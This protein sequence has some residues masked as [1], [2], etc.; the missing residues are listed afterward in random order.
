MLCIAGF[1]G[2]FKKLNQAWT[3]TLGYSEEELLARPYLDFVHPDDRAATATEAGKSSQGVSVVWFHNRYGCRDGS[4]R[5]LLWRAAPDTERGLIYAVARDVTEQKQLEDQLKVAS[6][7][8]RA[9]LDG[10]NFTIISTRPDGIIQTM[11]AGALRELGYAAEEL[12]GKVTPAII[13]DPG[14][15]V[16]RARHLS[17]ELG[18]P[19]EP[20]FETFIAKARLGQPD[21]NE[22]T[23]IRKDGSRFPIVLSVT[24][25]L[26]ASGDIVGFL[27]IGSNLTD[28]KRAEAARRSAEK[29][30]Q[31]IMDNTSAVIFVKG[32]DG[33][34]LLVNRQYEGLFHVTREEMAGKRDEDIFP[35]ELAHVL[36]E[37]DQKAI[38][39]G[40]P[41]QFEEIV[42]HDDG[43]HTY[44]SVKFP[45]F[46]AAGAVS[47]LCGI[48]MDITD[49]KRSEERVRERESRLRAILDNAVEG[50][51]TV[52]EDGLIQ[53]F[54]TAAVQMFGYEPEEVMGKNVMVLMGETYH[55]AHDSGVRR[56]LET[57]ERQ[58]IGR[59]TEVHG[60]HKDG[61]VFP[62]ELAV[63]ET[64]VAGGRLFTGM[65]H[66][67]AVRKQAEEDLL[68]SNES[69]EQFAYVASHDLKEPLRMVTSYLQ[70]L[71]RRYAG[72][73]D[74][75]AREFIGFAVDGATRMRLLIDDLLDYSRVGT[76][77]KPLAATDSAAVLRRV[78]EDLK[79]AIEEAGASVTHDETLPRVLADESQVA[80]VFQNLIANSLKFRGADAPLVHVGA[81][82][83][84]GR[85][86]FSVKDN[87]IG[88]HEKFFERIFV[89]FQ[90]LHGHEQYEGTGIGLAVCKKIIERH[91]GRLWVE[92]QPGHGATFFFTLAAADE[93][94]D[95]DRRGPAKRRRKKTAGQPHGEK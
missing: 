58:V 65:V 5:W 79:L 18:T 34:Y 28:R 70:L 57:G 91:E 36:Q 72:K 26:D 48:A 62:I 39:A 88:I 15:V 32:V 25:L 44:V 60:L 41:L 17:E 45:L 76:R 2:Y 66:D 20:G 13:H 49:R 82:R 6:S 8:Q 42:L 56:F 38:E 52:G 83:E 74:A 23:Y 86:I 11:N 95:G 16:A 54:N 80:Q 29:Q 40:G 77:G 47:A 53:S 43:L 19:V 61:T 89:I 10:A 21:E 7:W 67:I 59:R 90:R 51:I 84:M 30:M 35:P 37:N 12:I 33:R 93:T 81:R 71:E 46:D 24:A 4:Y 9:I 1:D 3:K 92:S 63:S 64:L 14:E 50:I 73:L 75:E 68:R 78:C 27:G 87:G 94:D 85:W 69:L 22:W 55:A 31:A